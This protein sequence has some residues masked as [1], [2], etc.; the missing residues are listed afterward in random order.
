MTT[1]FRTPGIL[2]L[3][4][5]LVLTTSCAQV[6]TTSEPI[7]DKEAA[8]PEVHIWPNRNSHSRDEATLYL[9]VKAGSLQEDD[10]EQGFAHFVEHMAFNGTENFPADQLRARMQ[11]LGLELES[12]SNAYTTLDHTAYTIHLN[13]VDSERLEAAIELLS[14]WAYRIEFSDAEVTKEIPVI[15]NEWRE[16]KS[17]ESRLDQE[18]SNDYYANSRH[19]NR[20]PIGTWV[21]IAS[22][23]GETL[24]DFYQRWYHPDNMA[25]IVA[26][27]V[28]QNEVKS[29]IDS[30]FTAPE[31]A[32]S[33]ETPDTWPLNP[34]AMQDRLVVTDDYTTY[35]YIDLNYFIE[36]PA[37]RSSMDLIEQQTWQA[38]LD[39]WYDRAQA[40][41]TETR[42]A[43]RDVGFYF[44]QV[45]RD[46]LHINFSAN[47]TGSDYETALS[48]IE[49]ERSRLLR[50][51]ITQEELDQWVEGRLTHERA[52]QDSADHLATMMINHVLQEW[53]M[54]GQ[55]ERIELLESTLPTFTPEQVRSALDSKLSEAKFKL[56]LIHPNSQ[57]APD[58]TQIDKWL[59]DATNLAESAFE[60]TS[61]Q[62]QAW[63]IQPQIDGEIIAQRSI[64]PGITEWTL[65]NGVS[66]QYKHSDQAPGKIYYRLVGEGGLNIMSGHE[67]MNA[68]LA[69]P[70][71]TQS[72]L[73]NLNGAALSEWLNNRGLEQFP[74]LDFFE[75]G[76]VGSG[77]AERFPELMRLL[78]V[79]LTEARVDPKTWQHV[80][81][82][83]QAELNQLA[84]HPH[85]PWFETVEATFHANDLAVRTMTSDEFET[86]TPDGMQ[87]IY[88][89]YF[90]GAQ[91]YRLAIVG[92]IDTDTVRR[93]I[94]SSVATL[95]ESDPVSQR[96]RNYPSIRE[97]S[98][99]RVS[100]SGKKQAYAVIRYDIDKAALDLTHYRTSNYLT[101]WLNRE[102]NETIRENNGS[103]Y[104]IN[105]TFDGFLSAQSCYSLIIELG[106]DP[107]S[108]DAVVQ[109]VEDVLTSLTDQ[110]PQSRTLETWKSTMRADFEQSVNSARHQADR[111]AYA[112][113]L[114]RDITASL[115]F[116]DRPV[117]QGAVLTDMLAQFIGPNA[118]RAELVW[119]P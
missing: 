24:R 105:T 118:T 94:Q 76:M 9:V 97:P 7:T 88:T 49:G 44:E 63:A 81:R 96:A 89:R 38:A 14:E 91:N 56:R 5:A 6:T 71:L 72:G 48:I 40:R 2:L 85:Q 8:R 107:E 82:Q 99:E 31:L 10:D 68:R 54:L 83:N 53:P 98:R 25:I 103:V 112:P 46:L 102:L 26:G 3:T 22:V 27:D 12:H 117:P 16:I 41:L 70:T 19:L 51:G 79:A 15:Q 57:V 30:Y 52:Q 1:P 75:R 104:S 43:V 47:L 4:L 61:T 28:D 87:D 67:I 116:E 39:I 11:S 66:V 90:A 69:L 108:V 62:H 29:L 20:A 36:S 114:D 37:P 92:D 80:R 13:R 111:I 33:G 77:P 65:S 32:D 93:A 34:E 95:P 109:S 119:M 59:T 23:T 58:V 60:Q 73:R 100:G 21:N 45:S 101:K 74:V 78:H 42:G 115:L 106:T 64:E 113:M 110:P 55:P 18:L 35:G 50:S 84:Q 17:G 86:V